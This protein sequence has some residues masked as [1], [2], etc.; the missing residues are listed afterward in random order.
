[1]PPAYPGSWKIDGRPVH[2]PAVPT[3]KH[4]SGTWPVTVPSDMGP[5]SYTLTGTAAYRWGDGA[6]AATVTGY[7]AWDLSVRGVP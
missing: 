3:G 1:V 4:L 6:H 7:A 5:G 2:A